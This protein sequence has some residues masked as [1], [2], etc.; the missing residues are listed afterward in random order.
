ML[1]I[2]TRHLI[3]MSL[4]KIPKRRWHQARYK[5][6]AEHAGIYRNPKGGNH[7]GTNLLPFTVNGNTAS[8]SSYNALLLCREEN[9]LM[10][11]EQLSTGL[12]SWYEAQGAFCVCPT[13]KIC[14]E[15]G[16]STPISHRST[17]T[18][19]IL[20]QLL[21]M[22]ISSPRLHIP[23]PQTLS[24]QTTFKARVSM[25]QFKGVNTCGALL[26]FLSSPF[27]LLGQ[28]AL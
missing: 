6:Q 19:Q 22:P 13:P 11:L 1:I 10:I 20:C 28:E 15:F 27:S 8:R 21:A 23:L 24:F 16:S 5:Q 3:M 7:P 26:I 17:Y 9:W 14:Q 18:R 12:V 2:Y 4:G 25:M